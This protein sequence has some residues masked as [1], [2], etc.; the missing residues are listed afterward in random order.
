[1]KILCEFPFA[2]KSN[3][4]PSLAWLDGR[5]YKNEKNT[6]K[7]NDGYW[8]PGM[9]IELFGTWKMLTGKSSSKK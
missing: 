8:R 9:S 7:Y 4:I 6:L 5:E 1:M 3:A 2:Q